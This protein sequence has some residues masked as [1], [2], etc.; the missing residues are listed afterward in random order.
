[1]ITKEQY[2]E[3]LLTIQEYVEQQNELA[4]IVE[5]KEK[6]FKRIVKILNSDI[7]S[8]IYYKEN[9]D[10]VKHIDE[11]LLTYKKEFGTTLKYSLF[12]QEE[13]KKYDFLRNCTGNFSIH[14]NI[15]KNISPF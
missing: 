15:L 9:V 13:I 8:I 6:Y 14:F 1:M 7:I 12:E 3:A 4:G 10:Y 11:Y 2:K 5:F